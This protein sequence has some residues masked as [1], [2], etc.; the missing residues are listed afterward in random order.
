MK[1]FIVAT[2]QIEGIHCWPECQIPEVYFLRSPH[3]HMF[4]IKAKKEVT[5]SNREKEFIVLKREIEFFIRNS[6]LEKGN[7]ELGAMS[8]EMLAEMLITEFSLS[9][10]S[11]YEDGENGAEVFA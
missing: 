1:K 7:I 5:D 2:L 4:H 6:F 9:S 11:V 8:C 10:C 3:R